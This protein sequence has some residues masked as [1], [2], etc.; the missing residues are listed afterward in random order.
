MN[1]TN[2]SN[3]EKSRS[4]LKAMGKKRWYVTLLKKIEVLKQNKTVPLSQS[5][6]N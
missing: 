6:W 4:S 3:S 1:L 5:Q 2:Q